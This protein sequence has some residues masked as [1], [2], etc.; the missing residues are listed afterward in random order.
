MIKTALSFIFSLVSRST[1]N[2]KAP[3]VA[4]GISV[5]VL[6]TALAPLTLWMI[7]HKDESFIVIDLSYGEASIVLII[8]WF[9]LEY[10]RRVQPK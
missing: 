5:V 1:N 10:T 7:G 3:T 2:G 9:I 8:G 6:L 4:K